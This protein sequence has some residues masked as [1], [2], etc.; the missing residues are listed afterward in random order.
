MDARWVN[1]GRAG[2]RAAEPGAERRIA[3]CRDQPT[4]IDR[5]ICI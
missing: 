4:A 1:C 5:N 3:M 2:H